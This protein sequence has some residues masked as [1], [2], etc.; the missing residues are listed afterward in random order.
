MSDMK[1]DFRLII[2]LQGFQREGNRKRGIGRYSLQLVKSLIYNYPNHEYILFANASLYD[3]RNE[4]D[5]ELSDKNLNVIYFEW[6]PASEINEDHNS[7][8]SK[9]YIA[10]QLRSYALS[11]VNA[12]VILI[13]SFFDGFKDNTLI[14]YDKSYDL[15]PIVSIIYDLI[16][17]INPS[18]YLDND[19]EYKYF[20]YQKIRDLNRLDAL[21]TIS[22]SSKNEILQYTQ[23]KEGK[24][25]NISAACDNN[26]FN[27]DLINSPDLSINIQDF[28]KYLLYVGAL[29]PRKNLF[30]LIK[31]YSLLPIDLLVKYKLVLVGP[32]SKAEIRLL[33]HWID[34]FNL[35]LQNIIILPFVSDHDL[36]YLYQNCY[37][38]VFPSFHEGFGLPVLEA[39]CCGAPV[40]ASNTT[41][42]PEILSLQCALFDPSSIDQI[43]GLIIKAINNSE[44]Y[45]LLKENAKDRKNLFSWK[46]TTSRL[47]DAF[48]SIL[49]PFKLTIDDAEMNSP[50]KD[51]YEKNHD[52]LMSRLSKKNMF[53]GGIFTNDIDKRR[54]ASSIDLLNI[55]AKQFLITKKDGYLNC[56]WRVEGPFDSSY[57][58]AILNRNFALGLLRIGQKVALHSTEGTG[59]FLPSTEF[60]VENP[61]FRNLYDQS[62]ETISKNSIVSRNL[63]PPRVN[64]LDSI[65]SLFH[66]FGWEE[67]LF[68]RHW[69]D[70]FNNH[71]DCITVMSKQVKKILIDS[72]VYLPIKVSGLGVDHIEETPTDV[73]FSVRKKSFSFLHISSCFP[74]K[75]ID[76]LLK[77]YGLSFSSK[78]N[79]TLV[80]KTFPN[81]HN[82]V[83]NLLKGYKKLN[84]NYPDVNI[85]N[86]NLNDME[87]KSLYKQCNV[88]VAPSF[89]EGFNLTVAEAMNLR[90][91]VITTA[92]GGQMDFCNS[93]NSWLVDYDFEY[94][95][96][97]FNLF[98]S[99]WAKPSFA[100]LAKI[101]KDLYLSSPS[102]IQSKVDIAKTSISHFKWDNVAQENVDF[103]SF[104]NFQKK[105]K[106]SK[107]GWIST[108]NTRCGIATYS[109]HLLSEIKEELII[110]SS[111][112]SLKSE[113]NVIRCWDMGKDNLD[114]L[115]N[116][117]I[118][119]NITSIVIQFNYGF[120]DFNYL[121]S[122][123][124]RIYNHKI[125]IIIVLHSTIDP[126]SDNTKKIKFMKKSFS[127]CNRLLVHSPSDLN[128]LK[129]IGLVEN[130]SLFP[131]GILTI[132]SV[133]KNGRKLNFRKKRLHFSTYGFCLP[134]KGFP[135][136]IKAIDL[137]YKDGFNCTLSLYTAI[138][139]KD[140]SLSFYHQLKELIR[141]LSLA[142]IVTINPS[143]MSDQ[144]TLKKLSKTDLVIF[145]YQSTNESVSG[146]VR[147]GISS[148]A[149]VAVTPLPI[150]DDV[151]DVVYELPG[152][153]PSLISSGLREWYEKS[154]GKDINT[155]EKNWLEE[156]SFHK[157]AS[158]LYLMIKSI[159]LNY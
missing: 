40:I 147:Q 45:N 115:F 120:F 67:S 84:S 94:S 98:D 77:A 12:D 48:N 142:K 138:Y 75:G 33:H 127:L 66:S 129:S 79:V 72:G 56:V 130:V 146:A 124:H 85:I 133:K 116:Q 88:L 71:L 70:D 81:I 27:E 144:E 46:L 64:D 110:F 82:N 148:L 155:T 112:K 68:P 152:T 51:R 158:R 1:S 83:F 31:A 4:F 26:L 157:L 128:R 108:W 159:E 113:D 80:I 118:H 90:I 126:E 5:K 150:F 42:I 43:K 57:S 89:G 86:H 32:Y 137:L 16:P 8:Y 69:V 111:N 50:I 3:F 141:N 149:P 20:Y 87:V 107:I 29:D 62:L 104:L 143:F 156:H 96:T 7:T 38:F 109:E 102:L 35:S 22:E 47:V 60:L 117:I 151:S 65:I 54:V 134:N 10:T 53:K 55:Q 15:P 125:K 131:H 105:Q 76:I 61:I 2:D 106:I 97:H 145:P 17:L 119:H 6:Y 135:E 39:I 63:Y 59:D 114:E 11:L 21:L 28:G 121:N 99:V 36:V 30:S 78:D 93:S 154:Y 24:V 132:P 103:V 49:Y 18:D 25:F 101:M 95:N 92:W 37:L 140:V 14:D 139:D 123:I 136:L 23:F 91:P 74:R 41:S 52:L 19:Q 100:H 9:T 122:F 58:L 44:F 153:T 34:E 13:T 73:N